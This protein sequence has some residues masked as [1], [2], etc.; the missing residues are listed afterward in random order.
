MIYKNG[1]WTYNNGDIFQGK[2]NKYY[3]KTGQGML[4]F[5]RNSIYEVYSGYFKKSQRWGFGTLIEKSGAKYIGNFEANK[6]HGSGSY[7]YPETLQQRFKCY[8]GKW[9]NN[10]FSGFGNFTWNNGDYHIGHFYDGKQNGKGK[11]VLSE[12][13][14]LGRDYYE[15]DWFNGQIDGEV[16]LVM[17]DG[18][19]FIKIYDRGTEILDESVKYDRFGV[20]IDSKEIREMRFREEMEGEL[21]KQM[22]KKFGKPCDSGDE[23]ETVY[24]TS[25]YY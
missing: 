24:V 10:K 16:K 13:D 21:E 14:K 2:L 18:T 8:I 12:N 4:T 25:E 6:M 17:K 1:T 20:E 7:Y 5:N 9:Q 19:Y 23:C 3:Q 15:G 22:E 11:Y